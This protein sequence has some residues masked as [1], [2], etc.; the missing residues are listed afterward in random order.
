MPVID[1][2]LQM[3]PTPLH[4]EVIGKLQ[5]LVRLDW[6]G[7]RRI[8]DRREI[9]DGDVGESVRFSRGWDAPIPKA[10]WMLKLELVRGSN[11]VTKLRLN[12]TWKLFNVR[13]VKMWV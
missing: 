8:S 12:E 9:L 5:H 11:W 13:G 3:M 6:Q 1:T 7:V 2:R 4:G 10:C